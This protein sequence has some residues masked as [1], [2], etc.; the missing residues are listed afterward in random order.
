MNLD[1]ESLVAMPKSNLVHVTNIEGDL[2]ILFVN[3]CLSAHVPKFYSSFRHARLVLI[4]KPFKLHYLMI[5][6]YIL[7]SVLRYQILKPILDTDSK[8]KDSVK[9]RID[10]TFSEMLGYIWQGL[11]IIW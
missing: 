8:V 11:N 1:H 9:S 6:E 2:K 10:S 3:V 5:W 7:K 4:L